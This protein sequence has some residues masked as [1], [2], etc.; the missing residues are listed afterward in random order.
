MRRGQLRK[1]EL[2]N[3]GFAELG[4]AAFAT[5]SNAVDAAHLASTEGFSAPRAR[6][7]ESSVLQAFVACAAF[8]ETKNHSESVERSHFGCHFMTGLQL[9]SGRYQQTLRYGSKM[10][11]VPTGIRRSVN[12]AQQRFAVGRKSSS[13][14]MIV[15]M[16]RCAGPIDSA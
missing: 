15:S 7:Y 9:P 11:Q 5:V 8:P 16:L 13:V 6:T 10:M 14:L 3:S 1:A 2:R 12:H 4:T